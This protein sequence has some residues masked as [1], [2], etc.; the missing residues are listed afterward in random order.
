MDYGQYGN[1]R[2]ETIYCKQ[3]KVSITSRIFFSRGKTSNS[4][5]IQ[6]M[7]IIP[8]KLLRV[9]CGIYLLFGIFLLPAFLFSIHEPFSLV[10]D[11][12]QA[13]AAEHNNISLTYW[14][15]KGITPIEDQNLY[16][17]YN[18]LRR[19]V[20]TQ[21]FD[22]IEIKA[23]TPYA[24]EQRELPFVL[25]PDDLVGVEILSRTPITK[26]IRAWFVIYQ[27]PNWQE[28]I[29]FD[30]NVVTDGNYAYIFNIIPC[31]MEKATLC[32]RNW[33][34]NAVLPATRIIL[35]VWRQTAAREQIGDTLGLSLK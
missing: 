11:Y 16:I 26:E 6:E 14:V 7:I 13:N 29:I 8:G 12:I 2:S 17:Y 24:E 23:N 19:K 34:S 32:W 3:H 22:F 33:S 20:F 9:I 31:R 21:T 4:S 25:L 28:T 10:D 30:N 15:E 27:Q 1:F 35:R 5:L 18:Y